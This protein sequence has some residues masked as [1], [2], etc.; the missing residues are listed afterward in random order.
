MNELRHLNTAI[1]KLKERNPGLNNSDISLAI[2]YKTRQY[3]T[4]LLNGHST[5]NDLVLKRLQKEFQISIKYVKTGKGDIF[6]SKEYTPGDYTNILEED[7]ITSGKRI[8]RIVEEMDEYLMRLLKKQKE[9]KALLAK[10][11]R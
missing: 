11:Q 7:E 4:N 1:E 5:L 2:G 9:L 8:D 10:K 3:L 6:L